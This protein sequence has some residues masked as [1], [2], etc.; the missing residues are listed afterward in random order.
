MPKPNLD[1]QF[2]FS[3]STLLL[4]TTFI[5]L[6]IAIFE[7]TATYVPELFFSLASASGVLMVIGLLFLISAF[8]KLQIFEQRREHTQSKYGHDE[9]SL[10]LT[11]FTGLYLLFPAVVA[12]LIAFNQTD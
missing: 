5:C 10:W 1:R 11:V 12:T 6:T 7:V 2:Q 9:V 3:L 4:H 8:G